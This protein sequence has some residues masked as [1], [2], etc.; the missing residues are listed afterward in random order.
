M[1]LKNCGAGILPGPKGTPASQAARVATV[2]QTIVIRGLPKSWRPERPPQAKCLPHKGL[3]ILAVC[4]VAG[5]AFA[6]QTT[7]PQAPPR[8][9]PFGG[10]PGAPTSPIG[11]QAA[12]SRVSISDTG[13]ML[14]NVSLSEVI[15]IIARRL[16]INYLLDPRFKGGSVTIHTYG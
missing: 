10:R 13:F 9:T 7:T 4:C 16:K 15:D 2:G 12:P 1:S 14:E 11:G 3:A 6:Q 8:P 5:L